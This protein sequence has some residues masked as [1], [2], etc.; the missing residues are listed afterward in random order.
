MGKLSGIAIRTGK[1]RPM[2]ELSE[3]PVTEERGVADDFRGRPGQRQVT[4]LSGE[5]WRQACSEVGS[6]LPWTVRRAN[7]LVQDL[8]LPRA[9]GAII[10]VGSVRLEVTMETDPCSRMDEQCDG[11]RAALQP[12]WRGGVCCRVIAGGRVALGDPVRIL[13][14]ATATGR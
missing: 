1:R 12:D 9:A 7:F 11:L 6:D 3:A 13:E 14:P 4:L 8:D 10:E 2:Q 5:A